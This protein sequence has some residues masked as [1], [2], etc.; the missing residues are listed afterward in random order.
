MILGRVFQPDKS[1]SAG[2][3]RTIVKDK[4]AAKYCLLDVLISAFEQI[5]GVK[6]S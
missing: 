1:I 6:T 3:V 4:R 2:E 5:F